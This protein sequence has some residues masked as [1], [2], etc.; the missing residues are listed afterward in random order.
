MDIKA[1][2]RFERSK[3]SASDNIPQPAHS[4]FKE[5]MFYNILNFKILTLWKATMNFC[6]NS[7]GQS[8]EAFF[9]QGVTSI[10]LFAACGELPTPCSHQYNTLPSRFLRRRDGKIVIFLLV[11]IHMHSLFK[12]LFKSII[13]LK[14]ENQYSCVKSPKI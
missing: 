12:M 13:P 8:I 9:N 5:F 7:L 4:G 2:L 14:K 10:T 1:H 3:S 11:Q 6:D